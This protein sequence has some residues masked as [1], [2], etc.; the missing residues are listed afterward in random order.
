VDSCVVE[1]VEITVPIGSPDVEQEP[2]PQHKREGENK[3]KRP[4]TDRW[5][6]GGL[7]F[8]GHRN[9]RIGHASWPGREFTFF[10]GYGLWAMGYGL[11]AIGSTMPI[12]VLAV[13]GAHGFEE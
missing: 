11:L 5:G 12:Q 8:G 7:G 1:E 13:T 6:F 4:V 3:K 10:V 2:N 9:R